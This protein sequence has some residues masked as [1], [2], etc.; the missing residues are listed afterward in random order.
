[1]GKKAIYIKTDIP[2]LECKEFKAICQ[3]DIGFTDPRFTYTKTFG[4][5][6][7][8]LARYMTMPAQYD[9]T[10]HRRKN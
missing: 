5:Y 7:L 3:S 2:R 4:R 6:V 8:D 9:I 1:M 10:E